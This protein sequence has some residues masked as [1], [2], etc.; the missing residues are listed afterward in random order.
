MKTILGRCGFAAAAFRVSPSAHDFATASRP[1]RQ[2]THTLAPRLNTA[3]S[4][5]KRTQYTNDGA[6]IIAGWCIAK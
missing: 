5:P 2:L 6:K 4:S 1:F 3:P